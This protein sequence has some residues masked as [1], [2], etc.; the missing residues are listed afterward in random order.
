M[1]SK[2]TAMIDRFFNKVELIPFHSCWEWIG[3]KNNH[4]YGQ[5]GIYKKPLQY[6]HRWSYEFHIGPIPLGMSLDHLCRNPSCVRP[7]H[8]EPVT[9]RENC[10]RGISPAAMAAKKTHCLRGHEFTKES[11][12]SGKSAKS[13][14]CKKCYA[15]RRTKYYEPNP[16]S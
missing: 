4:G 16:P 7:E 6:A 12:Y 2:N 14:Q 1:G 5:I 11:I 10:L 15:I 9:H 13:R 8:L 3:A